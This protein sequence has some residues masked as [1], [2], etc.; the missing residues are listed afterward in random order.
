MADNNNPFGAPQDDA[1]DDVFSFDYDSVAGGL[2]TVPEGEYVGK[3]IDVEKATS[4]AGNPMWVWYFTIVEG[5]YSGEDFKIYT[6]ITPAALWKLTETLDAIGMLEDDGRPKKFSKA[7]VVNT[8]VQME[9]IPDSY[10]GTPKA[11]LDR[12]KPYTGGV[13]KKHTGNMMGGL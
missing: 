3:C 5:E 2:E 8:L 11:S 1:V 6:A 7:D 10:Q 9:I 12:V 13:G 4:K